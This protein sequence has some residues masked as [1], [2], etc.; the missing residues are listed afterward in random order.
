M[1]AEIVRAIARM[2]DFAGP[3]GFAGGWAIDL[4][5][6]YQSR[7]H[8]DIDV[9][10]LRTDQRPLRILAFGRVQQVVSGRLLEW[11]PDHELE[12]P[13]HEV[14]VAWPDG[15]E[16]EFLLNECDAAT[17]DWVFRRDTRVRR[18]LAATF[19]AGPI[20]PYL[21]PEVVL[22]YKS[23]AP[24]PKDDADFAAVLPRLDAEQC[25]WLHHA[26]AMSDPGHPWLESL[27]AKPNER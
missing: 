10:I 27:T 1:N 4:F 15:L 16:V 14:H 8:G 7:P 5:L 26:L 3:W 6:G 9:A 2:R 11:P 17:G 24:A 19:R 12:L 18:C 20:A 22:L 23:K 13:V 21:A 25:R